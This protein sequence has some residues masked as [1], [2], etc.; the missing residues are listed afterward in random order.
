MRGQ[1][2]F[3]DDH[4]YKMPVHF[5]GAP[6]FPA[7][8]THGDMRAL[9]VRF[10]TEETALARFIPEDFEL[11]QPEVS[12]QFVNFREVEWM[13]NGEYRLIQVSAPVRYG[14]GS[15]ALDGVYPLII[16][17]N[18]ACPILGGREE[19]GMPKVFADVSC[20]RHVGDH[21]FASASY[22]SCTFVKVHFW[23]QGGL[24]EAVI[25]E[26]NRNPVTNT[27][28]WR[29][30]PNLGRG[31]ASLSHATLYPQESIVQKGWIGEG[32]ID[33]T[34]LAAEEHPLQAR[35]IS[36]LAS[37]PVLGYAG[38]VMLKGSARL[39]VGDSMSLP[40]TAGEKG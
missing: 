10:E 37:L 31:G 23:K 2:R 24:D 29:Y 32:R 3:Q 39:N 38:A 34:Q 13:S 1:F 11:L 28:G 14:A 5:S 21:W 19:D 26:M 22:E 33:W 16:W 8:V 15:G 40:C 12:V 18:K 20:E 9:I 17:E 7:R 27:F 25:A 35:A 4:V 36:S 6:F 30:L